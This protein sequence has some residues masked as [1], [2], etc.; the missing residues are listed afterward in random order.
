M[1]GQGGPLDPHDSLSKKFSS[2]AHNG[3]T[4]SD[5]RVPLPASPRTWVGETHSA[6]PAPLPQTEGRNSTSRREPCG[7]DTSSP[8]H[9]FP[10]FS[11]LRLTWRITQPLSECWAPPTML[12]VWEYLG[13]G[14]RICMFPNDAEAAGLGTIPENH[15]STRIPG[16]T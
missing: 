7:S 3:L 10:N 1:W 2:Q 16:P 11:E 15:C 5:S 6:V 12:L 14:P 9:H 8:P 13:W 4:R